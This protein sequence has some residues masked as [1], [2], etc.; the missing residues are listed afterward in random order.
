MEEPPKAVPQ[1]ANQF[2]YDPLRWAWAEPAVWTERMLTALEQGV[3]GNR[4]FSLIDKVYSPRCLTAAAFQVEAN[5]GAAGVDHSEVKPSTGEPDAGN[6]PVRFGGRGDRI[7]SVL[8][9]PINEL[10]GCIKMW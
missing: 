5:Q 1:A 8:P 4:W 7:Q 3:K 2:G 9:T 6:P 10:A